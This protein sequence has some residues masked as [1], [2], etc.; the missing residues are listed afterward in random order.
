MFNYN[1]KNIVILGAG[2]TGISCI[3]FFISLGIYPKLMDNNC[4]LNVNLIPKGIDFH[5]GLFKKS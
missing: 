4:F 3:N 5:F 1:N 2:I